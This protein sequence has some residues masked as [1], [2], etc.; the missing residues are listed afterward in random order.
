MLILPE[1][2]A[3]HKEGLPPPLPGALWDMG[4]SCKEVL[5]QGGEQLW[6]GVPR[7][8]SC[9]EPLEELA[10]F[11]AAR[12]SWPALKRRL[13]Q[14]LSSRD[15]ARSSLGLVGGFGVKGFALACESSLLIF[16]GMV[17]GSTGPFPGP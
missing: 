2:L 3:P 16:A 1:I 13:L 11:W 17:R 4:I 5:R 6:A 9:R 8:S 14:P 7:T 12:S 10:P 15:S